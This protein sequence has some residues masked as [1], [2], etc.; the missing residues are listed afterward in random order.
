MSRYRV[1]L[2]AAIVIA[3]LAPQARSQTAEPTRGTADFSG[4][5]EFWRLADQL[6]SDHEPSDSAWNS[7]FATPGYAALD[8]REKRRAPITLAM[9]AAFMP[10][11]RALRDSLLAANGWAARVVRHIERLPAQHP[12]LDSFAATLRERDVLGTAVARAGSLLPVGTTQ[13]F[14]RPNIAFLFFLPDG[15]GYPSLIVADLAHVMTKADAVP[16]FAREATHFYWAGLSRQ[17]HRDEA[18]PDPG[19]EAMQSL[20]TKIAEESFA[21]QFDKADAVDLDDTTLES[22]YRDPEWRAYLQ[23]YRAEYKTAPEQLRALSLAFESIAANPARMKAVSDSA[24]RALPLEGRALGMYMARGIRRT[25]GDAQ[26]AALA[27]N[28]VAYF[29]AYQDAASRPE[30]RGAPYSVE[31]MRSLS[32]R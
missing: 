6:R 10:S 3:L 9:R 11:R 28:A 25:L 27:G 15:R 31:A 19:A 4:V 5:S 16:Y 24:A 2:L 22:R 23:Q 30:C 18:A 20:L 29:R 1:L 17:Q 12:A 21:D 32:R 8:A 13:R 7:L 26:F 14:G